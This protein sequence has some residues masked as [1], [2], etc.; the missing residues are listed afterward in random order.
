MFRH[1]FLPYIIYLPYILALVVNFP[2]SL[3]CCR[4]KNRK[5]KLFIEAG[6]KG[7]ESIEFKELYLSACEYLNSDNVEKVTIDRNQN[8]LRQIWFEVKSNQPTHY[9]Y[10][11]R[12]GSQSYWIAIIHSFI[13]SVIFNWYNTKPIVFCPDIAY[14]RWR[15][16]SAIVSCYSGILVTLMSPK[17]IG[18][19]FPHSRMVAP[20]IM[21]FSKETFETIDKINIERHGVLFIGSLYEPRTT[22]IN[23]INEKLKNRNLKIEI[24][25]RENGAQRRPDDIYWSNIK[26]AKIL[27]TT[28]NQINDFE[29]D[30]YWITHL[31][32]RYTEALVCGTLLIANYVP[33]IEKLFEPQNHFV[34]F[35][36]END[37]ANLIEYYL[38][39]EDKSKLI[40]ESG[41]KRVMTHIESKTF[42]TSIDFALGKSSMI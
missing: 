39:N 16:Q 29:N 11:P 9:L 1:K 6:T 33:G 14:R 17:K 2:L 5:T 22:I 7:W 24:I 36:D 15:T 18:A 20:S 19:M 8:Y 27:F 25:G 31:I 41:K 30:K 3:I 4:T 38:N 37:A 21:P 35:E 26:S 28:S 32:Y 34:P 13:I 42:W 23:S 40:A 10:D 12:T